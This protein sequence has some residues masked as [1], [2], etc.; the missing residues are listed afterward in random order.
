MSSSTLHPTAE[1]QELRRRCKEIQLTEKFHKSHT[2]LDTEVTFFDDDWSYQDKTSSPFAND[3]VLNDE[4][5]TQRLLRDLDEEFKKILSL[6][7]EDD[8][9]CFCQEACQGEW[10]GDGHLDDCSLVDSIQYTK[11]R[12]QRDNQ[13]DE[14]LNV[15]NGIPRLISCGPNV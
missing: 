9:S 12:Y 1:A 13:D 10:D 8:D 7:E 11:E 14:Q 3:G 5:E 6:C 4:S 2:T 15:S